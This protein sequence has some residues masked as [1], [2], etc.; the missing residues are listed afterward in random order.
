LLQAEPPAVVETV[1]V[2][3]ARLPPSAAEAAFSVIRIAPEDLAGA[4]RLDE[5]LSA[6]P[7]VSL[8]RRT[9][10]QASNPTTQGL[11]LRS[12]A[13][14]GAGRAL[15][16]LDGVPQNDPFGG[17]VIWSSLPPEG[18]EAVSIVRGGG[19][20]PY[21]A[22]ALTGVVD[23][24]G[25]DGRT[26]AFA[27]EVS[28]GELGIRR[29]AGALDAAIGPVDLL[30]VASVE[31]GDGWIPVRRE[32]GAA[33][34]PLS[35]DVASFA[36]RASAPVGSAVLDGRFSVYQEERDSGLVGA[37][38]RARGT[39]A[40]LTLAAAPTPERPGWR[41]QGWLIDSDLRNRSVAVAPGRTGTAPANDQ[42]ETP[43]F[44][45]GFN[46]ALRRSTGAFEWEAG[47]D[48]RGAEGESRELFR[49]MGGAFTR[50]RVAGGQ[51][52]TGGFY[53]EGTR[54]TGPWLLTG[55][56]RVDVVT[57]SGARR[58][59]RDLATGLPT[60][61]QAT[62]DRTDT[63]PT[64]RAGLRRDLGGR[65]YARAAAYAAFRP[66]TLNELHRPFR[67]GNDITEANPQLRPERLYGAEAALG[68]STADGDW[69]LGAFFNR[70]EDPVANVTV[71]V[72]PG[73]FPVAG[74]VPAGGTLRQRRNAGRIDAVGLE[75]E[76]ER[77]WGDRLRLRAAFAYT[78][79]EV[80]GGEDAQQLTGLRPAQAP[81][82]T[83]T[84]GVD[85]RATA[86]LTL[87]GDLRGE[88]LRWEDD[89]NTRRLAPALTVNT[90][91]RYAL[92]PLVTAWLAA[93]NL[94]D[95]EVQTGRTG[96]GVVAYDAPR[97]L[98][99]G[100]SLRR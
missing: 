91:A 17:W 58:D 28:G 32:R 98:R 15:V 34:A 57:A 14:S 55:G 73:V 43:A 16:T 47:G 4:P 12:F 45:Y 78:V 31:H 68:G 94:L 66:P 87:A 60:L 85:W 7:G 84:A 86:R 3:A 92:T 27:A 54:R 33:D 11:S 42:F 65:T 62:D 30:A 71:G 75:A 63:A 80:D 2:T 99:V 5:A 8:F 6:A 53:A 13:P 25:R 9:S 37:D 82:L 77:R 29:A 79:A 26:G 95:A 10:S 67:V 39:R 90:R 24:T 49:F 41:L 89:L 1:V 83:A 23:L 59:E 52:L 44:G 21:G 40:S 74:F 46:A 51:T 22:G 35:L 76:A 18:V 100:V 81:R 97:A 20:G 96:D 88:S 61:S 36:V 70:L 19:A 48:V 38:A 64:A 72:G 50:E 56:A 69:S 93:D